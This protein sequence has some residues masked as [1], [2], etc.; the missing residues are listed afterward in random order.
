VALGA[1]ERHFGSGRVTIGVVSEGPTFYLTAGDGGAYRL[2]RLPDGL[3]LRAHNWDDVS[4]ACPEFGVR[5]TDVSVDPTAE[6]QLLADWGPR[7]A[8]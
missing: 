5:W 7:P 3:V 4:A 2:T 6:D 8:A 1:L